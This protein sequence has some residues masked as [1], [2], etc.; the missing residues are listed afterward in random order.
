MKRH[1]PSGDEETPLQ[2]VTPDHGSKDREQSNGTSAV[3]SADLQDGDGD[4]DTGLRREIRSKYR[5]LIDTVQRNREDILS[6]SNN[7]LTEVLEEADRLFQNVK[8]T[9]EAALDAKLLV[10]ASD[11]GK[12]K[13]SQLV[14]EGSAFDTTVFAEHLLSFMGLNR[15]E[16]VEEG[17]GRDQVDGYLPSDAW[18]RL[19][20]RAEECFRTA[21]TFHFMMGSFHAEPPPP[22]QRTE[23][24]RKAP[25]KEAKRIMPTQLKKM[26]ESHQEATEKEVER[27]LACLKS[28]QQDDPSSPI[29]YYEFVIDPNSFSRTV[30][31]IFH[32]SFLVRDG[33]ARLCLDSDKLPCI[34]PVE[35]GEM[36]TGGSVS[37]NQCVISIRPKTWKELVDAFDITDAMIPPQNTQP[38]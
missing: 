34:A 5:D 16:N 31:N 24:Q 33:L 30:E 6:P 2:N 18:H 23:R 25:S 15:L 11:L 21:P 10:M 20:Q 8:Q 38:Q 28:Y 12:D 17:Q 26:E 29:S 36:E 9:R 13:A 32:T 3:G 27:I 37:Q 14:A 7:K 4:N 1:R 35:E 22:K 19:A